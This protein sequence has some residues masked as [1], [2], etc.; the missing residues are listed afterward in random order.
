MDYKDIT[1]PE[2]TI[3]FY[4]EQDDA[5]PMTLGP[6]VGNNGQYHVGIAFT[7]LKIKVEGVKGTDPSITRMDAKFSYIDDR[8]QRHSRSAPSNKRSITA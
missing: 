7:H 1:D 8:T 3:T 2:I 4:V 5:T 6:L